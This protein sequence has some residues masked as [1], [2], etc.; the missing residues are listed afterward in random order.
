MG[1][2]FFGFLLVIL[3]AFGFGNMGIPMGM[4]PGPEDPMMSKIAPDDCVA[5]ASWS[6]FVDVDAKANPTEAWMSQPKVRAAGNKFRKAIWDMLSAKV[7][8]QD[9][10]V[11]AG[12]EL[13]IE[14]GRIGSVSPGAFYADQIE[15]SKPQPDFNGGLL[16]SLG[17]DTAKVQRQFDD[18]A[19]MLPKFSD[20]ENSTY[21]VKKIDGE[22]VIHVEAPQID[23]EMN[24]KM[25]GKYFF[26]GFGEGSVAELKK[27]SKTDAPKWLVDLRETLKIDRVSSVSYLNSKP[28]MKQVKDSGLVVGDLFQGGPL[29]K[30]VDADSVG[31]VS[32]VDSKGFLT[33]ADIKK[34]KTKSGLLSIIELDPIPK[35]LVNDIPKDTNFVLAT[36]ISTKAILKLMRKVT[37]AAG[38]E[39][40]EDSLAEFQKFTGVKLETELLE[41]V[42]DF[43]YAYYAVD[44]VSFFDK[45]WVISVR[46]EDE[47]SFPA[48][49]DRLNTGLRKWA[50]RSESAEFKVQKEGLYEIYSIVPENKSGRF[51]WAVVENQWY[52]AAEPKDLADHIKR[53]KDK[54]TKEDRFVAQPFVKEVY[55]FGDKS[56][57][58]APVTIGSI[59]VAKNIKLVW[60]FFAPMKRD[61]RVE[62]DLD[63]LWSDVPPLEE[64]TKDVQSNISAIYRIETGFQLYQRQT[65][66]GSSPVVALATSYSLWLVWQTTWMNQ[67]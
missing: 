14:V 26:I 28:I 8:K 58:G 39:S 59:D 22:K 11:I 12:T 46:I 67:K 29:E 16:V 25:H 65:Y 21:R 24:L 60:P 57:F 17:D 10:I 3:F 55:E 43:F 38:E 63:F 18:F 19:A 52:F 4:A 53:S 62:P 13:L 45:G 23:F 48:I 41:A 44:S 7:A 1:M 35:R 49:F 64:L 34:S 15:F 33:R 36:R 30:I 66:P 56:G 51:A 50:K 37:R 40:I 20:D 27:N 5:Y 32:G 2:S 47:M 9:P 54:N 42:G 6:G 31:W 61:D